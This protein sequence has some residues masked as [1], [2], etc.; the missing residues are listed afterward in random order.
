MIGA[1]SIGSEVARLSKSLGMTTI[2][3]SR[4][5]SAPELFD[6]KYALDDL[7]GV[8]GRADAV[9]VALPLTK[10][11]RGA[12]GYDALRRAKEGV[13]VVNVGRG[14]TV[15]HG[16]LLR[17]LRERPES[18]YATDVFWKVKGRESFSTDAWDLPNFAGTLHVSGVPVGENLAGVKLAAARNVKLYFETGDALNR[19]D[20]S[21]YI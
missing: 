3:S 4:S 21:E 8:I 9:V 7:V 1:G 14:E 15:S 16:D 19:V 2:G 17:W 20:P 18:R 12:V 6:E 11:T 5:Y 10:R 13:I